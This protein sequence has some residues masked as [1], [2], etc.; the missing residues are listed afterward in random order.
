MQVSVES[1]GVLERR[2]KVQVPA[3]RIEREV[4]TRLRSLG[5]RAKIKGFRP[6]KVPFKVV[7]QQYGGQVREEV[8]SELL[9][10][11]YTE[12]LSQENLT[13]AGGPQLEPLNVEPGQDLEYTATFEVYPEIEVKGVEGMKVK[14]PVAEVTES[15]IDDM[16]QNLREQRADWEVVERKAERG[17]RVRIDFEGDIKGK[18][19]EGNKGEDVLLE[20]GS[21]RM[22]EGFEEKLEGAAAGEEVEFDVKFPKDYRAEELAGKKV[23]FKV[24]IR[25]VSGKR[26]P[27]LDEEFCKAFGIE[28]GGIESLREEVAAN[29]RRELEE[30]VRRK[31]KEQALDG[32]LK[33]NPIELPKALVDEEIERL[34]QDA[35]GRLGIS[36]QTQQPE[37]PADLFEEDARRRVALGLLIG[38]VINGEQLK[39]DQ[40]RV[41]ETIEKMV[42]GYER[43][44]E[45]IRSYRSN[46]NIMRHIETLVLEE[47]VVD[48]LLDQ[49]AIEDE[50]TTFKDVMN[51]GKQQA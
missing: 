41:R 5:K 3:E 32:L 27:E 13:P 7:K 16:V 8:L 4:E 40:D 26:L 24:T 18:P 47:Q 48:W 43:P 30:T 39:I 21:G 23:H 19:F 22:V 36:D 35:L 20:L 29:M 42:E 45:V 34:R 12:A 49:A 11:T 25:E 44:D 31:V 38:E 51:F 9:R 28:E 2:M 37:L 1:T 6:G 17:D 46:P 33:A 14:R 10:S 15:D 50:S